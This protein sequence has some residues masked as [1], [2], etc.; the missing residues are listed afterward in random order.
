MQFFLRS[1]PKALL[2]IFGAAVVFVSF[3][4]A[5]RVFSQGEGLELT[6]QRFYFQETILPDH[7]AYPLFM[8]AD[9]IRLSFTQADEAVSLQIAYAWRRYEHAQLLLQRGYQ[10]LAFSTLTKGYKY[11][12]NALVQAQELSLTSLQKELLVQEAGTYREA[13]AALFPSFTNAQQAELSRLDA[14]HE[15]LRQFFVE[16][17]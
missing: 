5:N 8:A 11:H 17:F 1:L 16:T 2:L 3:L 13:A 12:S 10:E 7:V 6:Q 4:S 9:R 14:E 15:T